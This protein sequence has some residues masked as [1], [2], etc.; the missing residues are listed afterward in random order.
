MTLSLAN[1]VLVIDLKS[2]L[3]LTAMT[4]CKM[5]KHGSL[6]YMRPNNKIVL[7]GERQTVLNV[8]ATGPHLC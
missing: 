4:F 7:A 6:I 5:G 1:Q 2:Q 8:R 3:I